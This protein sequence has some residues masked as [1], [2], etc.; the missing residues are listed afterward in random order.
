M[1]TQEQTR[2]LCSG[3][4]AASLVIIVV[5]N[6]LLFSNSL[7]GYFL[8]DDFVHI[9]YLVGLTSG[10]SAKL[11]A[12]LGQNFY[13]N[14]M[15]AEGTTFY[16]PL[17]SLTLAFDYLLGQGN[18]FFFHLTNLFYHT[19]CALLLALITTRLINGFWQ[20]DLND[21]SVPRVVL[22]VAAGVLFSLYPL[23]CEVINWVIARV[24]SVALAF[25]LLAFYLFLIKAQN[26]DK[27]RTL[28]FCCLFAFIL[29]LMSK[30][31]A[32]TLPAVATAYLLLV[33]SAAEPKPST[34][35]S[36][37][38]QA[39]I[40]SSFLWFTVLGYLTFRT[41]ALGTISGGYQ[42]SIGQGLSDSLVK[43]W[44][45]GSLWRLLLPVNQEVFGANHKLYKTL[46]NLYGL[47]LINMALSALIFKDKHWQPLIRLAAFCSIWSVLDLLPTY[48]VWNLLENLQGG[49]FAYFATAPLMLFVA[50]IM[51]L[52]VLLIDS[53]SIKKNTNR[54]L[55]TAALVTLTL[56][57]TTFGQLTWAH[58][59]VWVKAQKEVERFREALY[60]ASQKTSGAIA[61]LNIPQSYKGAHMLYN[62]PT[63]SVMLK[64][65][66]SQSDIRERIITFEPATFG[67]ANLIQSL[68]LKK[69]V[70]QGNNSFYQWNR[71]SQILT[72]LSLKPGKAVKSMA[73]L[74]KPVVLS[75]TQALVSPPLDINPLDYDSLIVQVSGVKSLTLTLNG[76]SGH[77]LNATVDQTKQQAIFNLS[78]R[79]EWT[80]LP[81]VT[82]LKLQ[83]DSPATIKQLELTSLDGQLPVL[84][85]DG[86]DLKLDNDGVARIKGPK[87]SFNFDVSNIKGAASALFELSGANSWFEHYSGTFRDKQPSKEA[88]LSGTLS[89]VKGKNIPL[90]FTGVKGH[91]F[92]ELRIIALDKDGKA[93]GYFSEP[94][95]FQL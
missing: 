84:T 53:E 95:C 9:D 18:P 74:P 66:L 83:S 22:P 14:W 70:E 41:V 6:L 17:I 44:T 7:K 60:Q 51:L 50:L 3:T 32:V 29:S 47:A 40:K 86:R 10:G 69:L 25:N 24:D 80:S 78:E 5:L 68:R 59:Q 75:P 57:A 67:D 15:Q 21:H 88:G 19:S 8:A 1:K 45:D 58:N 52:P 27:N 13:S 93:L 26:Q 91:G 20:D 72:A 61:I 16:R 94:L 2:S 89:Q 46:K 56:L 39:L 73:L 77:R 48:Q 55:A 34:I 30:E 81:L 90:T 49:R 31:M 12:G 92:F 33:P 64:P 23:H 28:T 42:G 11:L 43:R 85:C 38:R 37:L 87:A 36:K 4:L 63:M 62:A 54:L 71:E 65:P 82:E 76:D 35:W 79:K